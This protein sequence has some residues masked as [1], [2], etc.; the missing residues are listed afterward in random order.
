M[1]R[2]LFICNLKI[3]TRDFNSL[4]LERPTSVS[5]KKQIKLH[6][7]FVQCWVCCNVVCYNGIRMIHT[8]FVWSSGPMVHPLDL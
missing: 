8:Q 6:F 2:Q 4:A 5:P 7:I 1:T 3:L